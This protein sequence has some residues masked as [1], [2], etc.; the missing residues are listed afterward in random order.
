VETVDTVKEGRIIVEAR[1]A[2]NAGRARVVNNRFLP[3]RKRA[4][5]TKLEGVGLRG[6][7]VSFDYRMDQRVREEKNR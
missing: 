3:Q 5:S 4:V 1:E 2:R 7:D 6:T